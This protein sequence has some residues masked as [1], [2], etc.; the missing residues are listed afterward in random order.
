MQ[1]QE[2]NLDDQLLQIDLQ[3]PDIKFKFASV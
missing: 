3:L 1:H 2:K